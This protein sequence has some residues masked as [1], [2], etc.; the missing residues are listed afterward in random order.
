MVLTQD[1]QDKQRESFKCL[2]KYLGDED[3]PY[4]MWFKLYAWDGVSKMGVFDKERG[5]FKSEMSIRRLRFR[6]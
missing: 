5:E 1:L 4:P 2:A 3:A 6:S